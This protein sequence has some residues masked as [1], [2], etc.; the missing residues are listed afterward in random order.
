MGKET[1]TDKRIARVKLNVR[2]AQE[3]NDSILRGVMS[4]IGHLRGDGD[5]LAPEVATA[6]PM[7]G[8]II[9]ELD[10]VYESLSS[11]Y[12]ALDEMGVEAA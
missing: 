2:N 5:S 9:M 10:T 4:T 6:V 8:A 1:I 3:A 11:A 12:N 7:L